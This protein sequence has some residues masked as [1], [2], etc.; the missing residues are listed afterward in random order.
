MFSHV[1][2]QVVGL[3]ENL[4]TDLTLVLFRWLVFSPPGVSI[5]ILEMFLISIV[6]LTN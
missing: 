2:L 6:S 1:N 4:S 5:A 3:V